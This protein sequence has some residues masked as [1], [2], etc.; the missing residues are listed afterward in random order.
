M[1]ENETRPGGLWAR[2]SKGA[3]GALGALAGAGRRA[4]S[5]F[6]G[7]KV[8]ALALA[9]ALA[10]GGFFAWRS[11]S[12]AAAAGGFS[13]IR[14]TT[15]QKTSLR[16]S[17][18]A[19]GTVRSAGVSNVT[20]DSAVRSYKVKSVEVKVG[21]AVKEGDVIL[22]LDT[23]DLLSDI[24]KAEEKLSENRETLL[25]SYNTA[26]DSLSQAQTA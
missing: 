3:R 14:T 7:H 1:N 10:A 22:T 16:E 21:D 6:L 26:L 8:V 12:R 24:E 2:L 19:T 20:I 9:A 23:A 17:V 13:F 25:K 15:L 11:A 4:A 18:T 5:F